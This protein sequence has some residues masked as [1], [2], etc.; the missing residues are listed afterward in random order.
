M[1]EQATIIQQ[2]SV[3]IQNIQQQQNGAQGNGGFGNGNGELDN[4][5]VGN[6]EPE[7]GEARNEGLRNGEVRNGRI[8]AE[9]GNRP[10]RNLQL[11]VIGQEPLYKRFSGMKPLV[12]EGSN[13]P[14]DAEEW[15]SAV[16]LIM[17]FMELNDHERVFCTSFLFK[18]EARY[19]WDYVK[20]R[21]NVNIMTWAE[22]VEEFNRK[23]FNPTA[24]SAQQTEFLNLKQDNMIVDVA[25]KKFEQLVQLCSYLVPTEEHRVKRMLE[26]FKLD[27]AL[28]IESGGDQSKTTSDCI[29][30]AFRAEHRLN[31]LKEMRARMFESM[32]KQGEQ[33]NMT[34]HRNNGGFFNR[35]KG[36]QSSQN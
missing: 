10:E 26:M 19:W 4:N 28:S 9:G 22:F 17:N 11:G 29:K 30:R 13:N 8:G 12:F 23:F 7:N 5:R 25:V 16:Q 1:E 3:V 27:I 18:R 35:N 33:S 15:L 24:M 32:K 21:K 14:L 6:R 34:I 20:V 31:Q 36:Q 2:Q